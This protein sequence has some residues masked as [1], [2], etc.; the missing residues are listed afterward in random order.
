MSTGQKVTLAV[1]VL[2]VLAFVVA[3]V[4][5][6]RLGAGTGSADESAQCSATSPRRRPRSID[7][8]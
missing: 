7:P 3:V 8:N 5:P 2:L 1:L 4:L 6:G